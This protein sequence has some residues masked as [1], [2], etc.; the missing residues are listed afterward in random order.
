[1]GSSVHMI[2][3]L[4]MQV[5]RL[6]LVYCSYLSANSHTDLYPGNLLLGLPSEACNSLERLQKLTGPIKLTAIVRMDGAPLNETVPKYAVESIFSDDLEPDAF[7]GAVMIGDWN[8]AFSVNSPPSRTS[9]VG[10]YMVPKFNC[11]SRIGRPEDVWMLACA[12]LEMFTGRDLFGKRG[13]HAER[14]L[15]RMVRSLGA[16]PQDLLES[17]TSYLGCVDKAPIQAEAPACSMHDN[18]VGHLERDKNLSTED[19][20][21]LVSF[22]EPMLNYEATERPTIDQLLQHHTMAFFERYAIGYIPNIS[23]FHCL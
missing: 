15:G 16:P 13:D 5:K 21:A 9:F 6:V 3:A 17:W 8:E 18:I 4:S 14:V 7:T 20:Q 1:M 10:P 19:L 12:V 23:K 2:L 11:P 22:L